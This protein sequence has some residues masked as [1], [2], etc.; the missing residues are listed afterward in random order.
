MKGVSL[1][2]ILFISSLL[3]V[4]LNAREN[5]FFPFE[6]EE[7]NFLITN[8]NRTNLPLQRATITL[9]EQARILQKVTLEFKN[10]D[11]TVTSKSIELNNSVDWHLPIFISQSYIEPQKNILLKATPSKERANEKKEAYK[12]ILSIKYLSL[13]SLDTNLK[14]VTSDKIIKD[15]LLENPY[16]IVIDFKRDTDLKSY[17]KKNPKNVFKEIRVGSHKGYYRVVIEIEKYKSY[18]LEKTSEGYLIKLK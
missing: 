1:I 3:F 16:R 15:F 4:L 6:G 2:K 10:D 7:D 18:K 14:L 12:N 11:G 9:P 8:E 5:P 17:L 13:F